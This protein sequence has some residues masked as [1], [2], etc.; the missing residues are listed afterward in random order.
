VLKVWPVAVVMSGDA[1]DVSCVVFHDECPGLGASS[2]YDQ[3]VA[4]SN[5][6]GVTNMGGGIDGW[7]PPPHR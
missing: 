5:H 7:I 3:K 1:A 6:V 4:C 2:S